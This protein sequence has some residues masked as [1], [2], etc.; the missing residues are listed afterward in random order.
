MSNCMCG[1]EEWSQVRRATADTHR[2][3]G[4]QGRL[5]HSPEHIL[6]RSLCMCN[7]LSAHVLGACACTT[8]SFMASMHWRVITM[9][10]R[11]CACTIFS[12]IRSMCMCCV[13][14]MCGE[15]ECVLRMC[16][17]HAGVQL[18][19]YICYACMCL[20]KTSSWNSHVVLLIAV[21]IISPAWGLCAALCTCAL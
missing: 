19:P 4:R 11:R 18:Q 16:G 9:W 14:C 2:T 15:A 13:M 21:C 10:I 8:F 7:F 6:H 20:I 17:D 5:T 12:C 1:P 3:Q